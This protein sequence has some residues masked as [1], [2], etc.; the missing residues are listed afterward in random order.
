MTSSKKFLAEYVHA[1]SDPRARRPSDISLNAAAPIILPPQLPCLYTSALL[2]SENYR[3]PFG[4]GFTSITFGPGNMAGG[5]KKGRNTK[6][7]A[8]PRGGYTQRSVGRWVLGESPVNTP[9]APGVAAGRDGGGRDVGAMVVYQGA[10]GGGPWLGPG[11]F[12]GPCPGPGPVGGCTGR[13]P[14]GSGCVGPGLLVG[15][16]PVG[17]SGR[18]GGRG[19]PG[20]FPGGRVVPGPVPGGR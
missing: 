10:G 3:P 11:A 16:G 17:P 4:P 14:G 1:V 7:V 5:G 12:P 15:G 9:I 20:S 2:R 6:P 13:E 8:E 19:S 18:V